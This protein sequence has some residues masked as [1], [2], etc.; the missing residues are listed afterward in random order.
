MK[1]QYV[2]LMKDIS[3]Y[4]KKNQE[5]IIRCI[6]HGKLDNLFNYKRKDGNQ[7]DPQICK[8]IDTYTKGRKVDEW[9][10]SF[11]NWYFINYDT[12]S[13]IKNRKNFSV[14]FPEL[15]EILQYLTNML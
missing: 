9:V 3:K 12:G 7:V 6:F 5:A 10:L 4:D 1:D 2:Q 11:F 14:T 13:E 15:N 8:I